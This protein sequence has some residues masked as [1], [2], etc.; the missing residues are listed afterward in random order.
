[1]S[2]V[3]TRS[4]LVE[5]ADLELPPALIIEAVAIPL[6]RSM[7]FRRMRLTPHLP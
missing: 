3:T 7:W 4:R 2:S 5:R 1:M 6:L